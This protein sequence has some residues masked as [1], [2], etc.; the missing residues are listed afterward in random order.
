MNTVRSGARIKNEI[1]KLNRIDIIE[2]Y[3]W[4][5]EQMAADLTPRIGVNRSLKIRQEIE[6]KCKVTP[7]ARG[8]ISSLIATD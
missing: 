5:D 1:R 7:T 8:G 3:R 6:Q 4:I 2:I